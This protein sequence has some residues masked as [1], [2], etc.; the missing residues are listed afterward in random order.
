MRTTRK[1]KKIRKEANKM[2]FESNIIHNII[3]KPAKKGGKNDWDGDGRQNKRDCQPFNIMR[4]DE[5]AT[6][7]VASSGQNF[8]MAPGDMGEAAMAQRLSMKS[9]QMEAFRRARPKVMG[10]GI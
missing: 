1:K 3:G 9:Q 2:S 8:I 7:P 5:I 10:P 4:Q 6:I